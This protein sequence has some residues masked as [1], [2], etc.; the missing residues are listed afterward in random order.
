MKKRIL[1][2]ALVLCMALSLLPASVFA[3]QTP[4]QRFEVLTPSAVGKLEPATVSP[5][6]KSYAITLTS[7]GKGETE[8]LVNSPAQAGSEVYFLANPDDGYLAQIR[9][10][11]L[12]KSDIV[13]VGMDIWGFIMP[14][15]KVTLEV[16]YV[17][18]EG[19]DF[20]IQVRASAGGQFAL[21]RSSAK[22]HESVLLAVKPDAGVSY[23]PQKDIT[24]DEGDL[25]YLMEEQGIHYYELMVDYDAQIEIRFGGNPILRQVGAHGTNQEAGSYTVDK[26]EA[27]PGET[28][29][30][31]VSPAYGWKVQRV[32]AHVD[33]SG[34]P[35][36]FTHIGGN[37]YQAIMP[38]A[39]INI[40]VAFEAIYYRTKV[41]VVGGIGGTARL[42]RADTQPGTTLTLT[43]VPDDNYRVYSVTGVDG[44]R[45]NGNNTYNF[46]M[47]ERD[48][49]LKVVFRKIYNPVTVTVE[50]G[51]GGSAITNVTEAKAGD[52]VKLTC[53]PLE[54]YRIARVTGVKGLTEN[55]DG[56]YTFTMPDEAVN[57]KVLFLRRENP[58]FDV[59]ENQFFYESVLWAVKEGI[60]SG[61]SAT[62]FGPFAVCNRAQVVTFLWRYA[63]SPEPTTADNPFTDVPAEGWYTKAVLWAVENNITNGVSATEFGPELACNR[64][65]VVTFL[66]RFMKQPVPGLTEH[67][68]TDLEAGSWYEAPVLW[69]VENGIT[70]G[71][72]AN[73]FNPNGECQRAQVVTFLHRTSQ[74][75]PPPV[76]YA[77]DVQ[78]DAAMGTVTLSHIS[79]QVG[80]TV[81]ATV[82]PNEGYE[83]IDVHCVNGTDITVL[84]DTMYTFVMPDHDETFV[85]VFAP[86][87]TEPDPS[88]P[89]PTEPD[90]TEPEQPVKTYELDLRTN[91]NGEVSY[92]DGKNTAAP[93]E[94]IFFYAIPNPGYAL[95][96]VGIFNPNGEIDVSKIQLF[97]H[98]GDLYEL[99][100]ID[101]D[102]IMTCHFTPIG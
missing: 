21:E 85:A 54:G 95:T 80:D 78:F 75:P 24:V 43:C 102:I 30:V 41:T 35:L 64:A 57:L 81:T 68:F 92:V 86:I 73:T 99:V 47:P 10:S 44:I 1:A 72:T 93:G 58:F 90:P 87:A 56:T 26:T 98:G 84:S 20:F 14:S 48:I 39:D 77:L 6:A 49:E 22:R 27:Y 25:F 59:N 63:G 5:N 89:D 2:L 31:A 9:F 53:N 4:E 69:A 70:N 100:M 51:L 40:S 88:E 42:N 8:L 7:S 28:I 91:G 34:S 55:G 94:S 52:T 67:P 96:N 101:R 3:A 32:S 50:N 45:D 74:L 33:G 66:W 61:I 13:Y 37:R 76:V 83:L 46:V 38:D 15:N 79:A 12:S 11:G 16:S 82:I 71:A 97:E 62:D 23:D 18:A 36:N 17:A 60:T 65:Q 29:T 19:M